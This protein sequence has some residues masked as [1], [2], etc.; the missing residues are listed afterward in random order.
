MGFY[1]AGLVRESCMH[2][3]KQICQVQ[4]N[5]Y[6]AS[7][8]IPVA[9]VEKCQDGIQAICATQDIHELRLETDTARVLA[10]RAAAAP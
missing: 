4:N 8:G 1:K 6:K 3:L 10:L 7:S 5:P 2:A 9:G